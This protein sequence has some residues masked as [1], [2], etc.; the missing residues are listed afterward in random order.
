MWSSRVGAVWCPYGPSPHS[1]HTLLYAQSTYICR[2]QSSVWR[3][4]KYWP[5]TPLST[6]RVSPHPAP[7]A[8]GYTLAGRWGGGG[9][10]FWKTPD[11]GL[12]SYSIIPLRLFV[13]T[14]LCFI[15]SSSSE[16]DIV[17]YVHRP[18][19]HCLR[20]QKIT[21]IYRTYIS[22]GTVSR[23]FVREMRSIRGASEIKLNKANKKRTVIVK[24][25]Y[26]LF[27]FL[28]ATVAD[29]ITLLSSSL[30]NSEGN[31]DG[32]GGESSAPSP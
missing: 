10:I 32:N 3:L 18:S 2:V 4:P 16:N 17:L 28:K 6:Q 22:K 5:P 12:E 15:Y 26:Y 24:R 9:S 29:L 1:Q 19:S 25:V 31:G 7:K 11:I 20:R 14:Q 30:Q 27:E 23:E 21:R 8:R 13:W